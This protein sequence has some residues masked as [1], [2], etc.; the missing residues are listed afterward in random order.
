[1]NPFKYRLSFA[2]LIGIEVWDNSSTT[3]RATLDT[4][5]R[6]AYSDYIASVLPGIEPHLQ[7]DVLD[8]HTT[9]RFAEAVDLAL[10]EGVVL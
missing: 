9:E 10:S 4:A 3:D 8:A 5:L 2:V 6:L 7:T 1:M